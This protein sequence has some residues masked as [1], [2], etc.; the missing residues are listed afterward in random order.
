MEKSRLE[1]KKKIVYTISARKRNSLIFI[2]ESYL[3]A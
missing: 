2:A 1:K 3:K